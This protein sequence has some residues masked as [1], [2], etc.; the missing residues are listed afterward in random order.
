MKEAG[1]KSLMYTDASFELVDA[2]I[3]VPDRLR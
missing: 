3:P 2:D 1:T